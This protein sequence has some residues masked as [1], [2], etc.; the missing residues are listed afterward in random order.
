MQCS[1]FESEKGKSTF[2]GCNVCTVRECACLWHA[3]AVH[4]RTYKPAH[5]SQKEFRFHAGG[6]DGC[7]AQ[8]RT[9]TSSRVGEQ[10]NYA[11]ACDFPNLEH[12]QGVSGVL[13][14]QS[15]CIGVWFFQH[16]NSIFAVWPGILGSWKN[17]HRMNPTR[18][19]VQA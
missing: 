10:C 11:V 19:R 12:R 2:R 4:A 1:Q 5:F 17:Q 3:R 15:A 6:L 9:A 18:L 7:A 8:I 16:V 14:P 13:I